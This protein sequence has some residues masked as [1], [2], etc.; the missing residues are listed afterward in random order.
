MLGW[1]VRLQYSD[2]T[3]PFMRSKTRDTHTYCRTLGSESP[4]F[5]LTTYIFDVLGLGFKIIEWDENPRILL[6]LVWRHISAT[7]CQIIMSTYQIFML[8]CQLFMSTCRK[9]DNNI[10]LLNILFLQ[11]V[12]VP[13]CHLLVNLIYNKSRLLSD[14][15]KQVFDK[16]I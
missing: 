7:S 8:I 2:T 16:S 14:K 11:R 3:N 1:A 5:V 9:K 12:N 6:L 13:N 4:Q 10:Q 15:S